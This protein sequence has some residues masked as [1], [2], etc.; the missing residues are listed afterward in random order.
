MQLT[1]EELDDF[2]NRTLAEDIGS[3]DVTSDAVIPQ[4]ARLKA[5][6][7]A[8]QHLVV[9][10][11]PLA[12]AIVERVAPGSI[13]EERCGDGDVIESGG[14]MAEVAGPARGLL[15]AERS[16]L[17]ILQHLSGIATLTRDYVRAIEGTG[18]QVLDTRKTIPG[19]RKLEKY[20]VRMGGGSNH[21]MGL[22]DAVLI[23]D[24]HIAIAGGVAPAIEAAKAHTDLKIQVECDTL[25]QAEAALA[26][27]ADSLLLDNM[28]NDML[29]GA[30]AFNARRIPLEASGGVTLETV[31]DIAKTGVDFISVGRLTQSA[32]AV[33]IGLDFEDAGD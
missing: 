21:R 16:A 23:K 14:I 1:P 6:F 5:A 11:L 20:A 15:T 33:D 7:A 28:S 22:Y 9:A 31:H 32:P 17:N 25:A 12:K 3:G 27:G 24:N 30:V 29:R 13:F 8:R 18:A 4:D 10:G 2:I 26:A 19:L